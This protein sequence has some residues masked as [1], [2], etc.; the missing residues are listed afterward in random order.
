MAGVKAATGDD[1]WRND[2]LVTEPARS[3]L[4]ANE[5]GDVAADAPVLLSSGTDD[6]VVVI[7]RVRSL[8]G[9]M[10]AAGQ[11]TDF[12]VVDGADHDNIIEL[13]PGLEQWVADRFAGEPVADSCGE[14]GHDGQNGEDGRGGDNGESPAA[15]AVTREPSLTG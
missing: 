12:R 7:D 11:V 14:E 13:T 1:F 5:V 15:P 6:V 8:F 9:R 3:L 4:L 10:C 2:P